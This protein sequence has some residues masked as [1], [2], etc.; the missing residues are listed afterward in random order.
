MNR[1]RGSR[2]YRGLGP[3]LTHPHRRVS[4]RR[5]NKAGRNSGTGVLAGRKHKRTASSRRRKLCG[6]HTRQDTSQ[7]DTTHYIPY[8]HSQH[9]TKGIHK[10]HNISSK[11]KS[12]AALTYH[13]IVSTHIPYH[14]PFTYTQEYSRTNTLLTTYTQPSQHP[15]CTPIHGLL[16]ADTGIEHADESPGLT[17][18]VC[19]DNPN[20]TH[21]H[22]HMT[23]THI[24]TQGR[25]RVKA[26][27]S[28]T[29]AKSY[30]Q[31]H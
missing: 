28:P 27:P 25:R 2:G 21:T 30:T 18:P 19:R 10:P 13:S 22:T 4:D 9:N 31:T 29:L 5:G 12:S 23:N 3:S 26:S 1:S 20:K 7:Y 15:L 16:V 17:P 6:S 8:T 24:Y 11:R 14:I